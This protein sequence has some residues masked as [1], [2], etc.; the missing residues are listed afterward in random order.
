MQTVTWVDIGEWHARPSNNLLDD[1]YMRCPRTLHM[2]S[3]TTLQDHFVKYSCNESQY[4]SSHFIPRHCELFKFHKSFTYFLNA[5]NNPRGLTL[6]GDSIMGQLYIAVHCLAEAAGFNASNIKFIHD[7]FLRKDIPCASNCTNA[8]FRT[9][10]NSFHPCMGCPTDG[11]KLD[12]N[13]MIN[14]KRM[15]HRRISFTSG[16]VVLSS[17]A[18]FTNF[19][20]IIDS[21][22]VYKETLAFTGSIISN[23]T[24]KF[25]FYWIDLP[26]AWDFMKYKFGE[27]WELHTGRNEIARDVLKGFN[28]TFL[29]TTQATVKRCKSDPRVKH[30]PIHW[31]LGFIKFNNLLFIRKSSYS[32]CSDCNN[33]KFM[34]Y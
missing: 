9:Q 3:S 33:D 16:I 34:M 1:P 20:G 15:W 6:V 5:T 7:V 11:I 4:S 28:I 19:P 22:P 23:M 29:N 18:W 31:W 24:K 26:P 30:D 17:G 12:I 2:I 10:N 25:S 32:N 27:D 21:N 14:D 8:A 13:D